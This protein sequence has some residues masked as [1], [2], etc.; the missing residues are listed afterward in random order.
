VRRKEM[1]KIRGLMVWLSRNYMPSPGLHPSTAKQKK[2]KK[3]EQKS[4]KLRTGIQ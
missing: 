4:I 3:L 1:I 2:K